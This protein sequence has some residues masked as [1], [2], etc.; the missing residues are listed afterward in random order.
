MSEFDGKKLQSIS[1]GKVDLGDDSSEELKEQEKTLE[2]MINHIKKVLDARVK[3]VLVTNRLTDSPACIVAD[4]QIWGLKCSVFYNL[5]VN[6]CHL[7]SQCSKLIP[8]M[9]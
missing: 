4:E 8:I 1:K 9:L 3:D 6:K 7:A 2:P 5:L